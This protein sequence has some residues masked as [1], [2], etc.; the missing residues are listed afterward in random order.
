MQAW[1]DQLEK[2][3]RM[4]AKVC[5]NEYAIFKNPSLQNSIGQNIYLM[6]N[7]QIDIASSLGFW[8]SHVDNYERD[9][10]K[11]LS[12]LDCYPFLQVVTFKYIK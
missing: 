12:G 11:C 6:K 8:E 3:A 2:R 10:R 5:S 1:D 9:K 7:A 4:W